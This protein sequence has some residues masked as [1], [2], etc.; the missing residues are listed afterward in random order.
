MAL[1]GWGAPRILGEFMKLGF[2]IS[3]APVSHYTPRTPVTPDQLKRWIA[4]LRNH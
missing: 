1:D 3:E 2:I 4:F